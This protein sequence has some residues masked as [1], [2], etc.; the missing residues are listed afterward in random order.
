M[1][2]DT[3]DVVNAISGSS[4]AIVAVGTAVLAIVAGIFAYRKIKSMVR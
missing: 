3:T 1:T 4:T 2:W